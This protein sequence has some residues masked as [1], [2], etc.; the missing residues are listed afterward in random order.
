MSLS[1]DALRKLTSNRK[2]ELLGWGITVL[3]VA[4]TLWAHLLYQWQHQLL[5]E[6]DAPGHIIIMD[7]Y[8]EML[9]SGGPFARDPFPP[10][11][12]LVSAVLL[13][14]LGPS[15]DAVLLGVALFAAL[16]AA[17]LARLGMRLQGLAACTLL[18]LLALAAPTITNYSRLY[19]LDLPATSLLPWV[20]LLAISCDG[21][22]R[23]VRSLA[24]GVTLA[25]LALVKYQYLSW[26]VPLPLIPLGILI[27]RSR[28]ALLV[29]A[30][31]LPPLAYV[32]WR[33]AQR[34][35]S[36]QTPQGFDP[37]EGL[38]HLEG[39][40]AL[41]ALL[42]AA[43][44]FWR[45]RV[46]AGNSPLLPGLHLALAALLGAAVFL[47]WANAA[48]PSVS[49]Y[50]DMVVSHN[51]S[52]G[53][54]LNLVAAWR[55]LRHAWPQTELLLWLG[56]ALAALELALCLPPL[57]RQP[58]LRWLAGPRS[59]WQPA[60]LALAAAAAAA[61][62]G[63][64]L[65][66]GLLPP[67]TRY[68]IPLYVYATFCI[69]LPICRLRPTRLLLAPLLGAVCLLQVGGRGLSH[70]FP[71]LDAH[72]IVIEVPLRLQPPDGDPWRYFSAEV[73]VVR[74]P[75]DGLELALSRLAALRAG[76]IPWRGL[77]QARQRRCGLGY[78][79]T[80]HV[81]ERAFIALDA[82]HGVGCIWKNM[83]GGQ[84][85]ASKI[86][87]LALISVEP[88]Q[89]DRW[90]ARLEAASDRTWS[91]LASQET[92]DG[93]L[94]SVLVPGEPAATP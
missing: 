6:G 10:G 41:S 36:P 45:R 13:R 21:F 87:A 73:A 57:R 35:Q 83:A 71:A 53:R 39:V 80:L 9:F 46:T 81:E 85:E 37:T 60:V 62:A 1:K 12:Y 88:S 50:L 24:L 70:H 66:A 38:W 22:R 94:V 4:L 58:W 29:A 75:L 61:L 65:T 47:P 59:P 8:R 49:D 25:A 52:I 68:Y 82:V 33:L 93:E 20:L 67:N 27:F 54:E 11:L 5:P 28:A 89:Q 76:K 32:A 16:L 92:L 17:G 31:A 34:L 7:R 26:V 56:G 69:G 77:H 90:L 19:L 64:W 14:L 40:L 15:L 44:W 51:K 2:R 63:A 3:A 43:L 55:D 48:A 84:E 78:V 79:S 72:N 23:P 91:V 18:P 74:G 86:S 42:L 30:G